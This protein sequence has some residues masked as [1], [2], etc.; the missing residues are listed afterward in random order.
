MREYRHRVRS[1]R[2]VGALRAGVQGLARR[3]GAARR[4]TQG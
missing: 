3:L 4:N 1:A 2:P